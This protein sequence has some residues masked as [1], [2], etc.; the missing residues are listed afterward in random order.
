LKTSAEAS[1]DEMQ[2]ETISK[3]WDGREI[4]TQ[5]FV[6][7]TEPSALNCEDIVSYNQTTLITGES[8]FGTLYGD[9][10]IDGDPEKAKP[11][12]LIVID[13]SNAPVLTMRRLPRVNFP[14]GVRFNPLGLYYLHEKQLLHAIN[15]AYKSG[16]TRIDVF[17]IEENSNTGDL[18]A[19][20][21]WA[22]RNDFF[23]KNARGVINDLAVVDDSHLFV[24]RHL[25]TADG[26]NGRKMGTLFKHQINYQIFGAKTTELYYCTRRRKTSDCVIADR[27]FGMANGINFG[28]DEKT[29]LYVADTYAKKL[30]AYQ[31]DRQNDNSLTRMHPEVDLP[32]RVDNI[33]WNRFQKRL[34]MGTFFG[35]GK[36]FGGADEFIPNPTDVTSNLPIKTLVWSMRP[37]SSS[38][39]WSNGFMFIGSYDNNGVLACPTTLQ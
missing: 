22:W 33:E 32:V 39:D 28:N 19:R 7:D 6:L 4:N 13:T 5:C 16:G 8:D 12:N 18:E 3:W 9:V 27:N 31:V 25:D 35:L 36:T 1:V 37:G 29:L 34:F 10:L 26:R 17:K 24:T 23:N 15:H 38:A 30:R 21:K 2:N 20:W 14:A 11:G